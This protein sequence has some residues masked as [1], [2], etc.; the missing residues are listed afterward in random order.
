MAHW[1]WT[2]KSGM[3]VRSQLRCLSVKYH[4]NNP[5]RT[6]NR[7]PHNLRTKL[8][9]D[10]SKHT[11]IVVDDEPDNLEVFRAALEMLHNATVHVASSG[12]EA[13]SLLMTKHPTII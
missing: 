1:S 12:D 8:M 7:Y 10:F 13:L 9:S 6:Y 11:I 3:A 2:R 4:Q 5:S